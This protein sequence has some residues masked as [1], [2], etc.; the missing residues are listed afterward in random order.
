MMC[1]EWNNLLKRYQNSVHAHYEAVDR[2]SAEFGSGFTTAWQHAESARRRSCDCRTALLTHQR[3]HAC[4][5]SLATSQPLA[6]KF[7]AAAVAGSTEDMVL[8]DQGQAG[9]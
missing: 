7:F 2:L 1:M 5:D 4:A 9:G 8:G 6:P 3:Y